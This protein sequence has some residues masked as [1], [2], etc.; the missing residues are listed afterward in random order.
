MK[1]EAS[2]SG[3]RTIVLKSGA[4]RY[5]A[6][7]NRRGV[8]SQSKC[9]TTRSEALAWKRDVESSIDKGKRVVKKGKFLIRDI[10]DAYLTFRDPETNKTD[11]MPSNRR[12]DYLRV[13]NDLGDLA[14]DRLTNLD[15]A[16]YINLLLCEPTLQ[17]KKN[18]NAPQ[19]TY[20]ADTV[21]KFFYA[22]KK[23]VEWHAKQHGYNIDGLFA[24]EKRVVPAAWSGKR[25][26]R[27]EDGEEKG[28]YEAGIPR[29]HTYSRQDWESL[30][31]FVLETALR[32]QEVVWAQWKHIF[33]EG[34]KLRIPKEHTKTNNERVIPLSDR[35]KEI[36][37]MQK[38]ECPPGE[39]RIFWQ[40][41][42]PD[43]V[44][45]AF[46]RLVKRAKIRDLHF[47]DLRHEATS[48]LCEQHHYTMSQ[49]MEITGHKD[50]KTFL[51]YTHH[52]K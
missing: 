10:I 17:S 34:C 16:N 19:N 5:E 51:G 45:V 42:S 7:I 15:V 28:L 26:R 3:I 9:F 6:R 27:L 20:A 40:F 8:I 4:K 21:R 33:D 11:P 36:I 46:A 47:H 39:K 13:K 22:M 43:S 44:C 14:I 23:S 50:I 48:R 29:K 1:R 52:F 35:A 37:H 25:E 31:G 2:R 18:P 24:M 32:E 49:I 12:T 38:T 41:A 30:I